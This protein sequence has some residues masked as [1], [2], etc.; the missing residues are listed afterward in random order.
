MSPDSTDEPESRAVSERDDA[1]NGEPRRRSEQIS[2]LLELIG[3]IG[4]GSDLEGCLSAVARETARAARVD[5]CAILLWRDERLVP[6]AFDVAEGDPAIEAANAFKALGIYNLD[7]IVVCKQAVGTRAPVIADDPV[8]AGLVP[9]SWA[10]VLGHRP[11]AVLP[12]MVGDRLLGTMHLSSNGAAIARAQLGPAEAVAGP[13]AL[14]IDHARLMAQTRRRL[15]EKNRLLRVALTIGSTLDP[16]EVLRRIARESA[17][18]VRADTGAI[19]FLGDD[20]HVLQPLVGYHVPKRFLEVVQRGQINLDDFRDIVTLLSQERRSI[21]SDDVARDPHF[22]H[23]LFRR[24]PMRSLFITPLKAGTKVLG[25]LVCVWWNRRHRF[26]AETLALL[27]G[28][29]GLAAVAL[30]NANRYSKAEAMAVTRERLRVARELHDTLNETIFSTALKLDACCRE[31]PAAMPDLRDKLEEVKRNTGNILG[32]IRQ[33]IYKVAPRPM[34]AMKLSE[35]VRAVIDAAAE[36]SDIR[37]EFL[38][39]GDAERLEIL[40]KIIQEALANVVKHSRASRAEVRIDVLADDVHFAVTDDGMGAG[41]DVSVAHLSQ[42]AGH[43]GLQQILERLE[44]LGG[45]LAFG[46]VAPAGFRIAGRFPVA[47]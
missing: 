9:A 24:L 3:V 43:F 32:Q 19:Y 10:P 25:I 36:L 30:S 34:G 44:A 22:D 41:P 35:R 6:A 12:L 38:E 21:W 42:V 39:Q 40:L 4:Q 8:G 37:V 47:R 2:G 28:I 27:E 5:Q 23:E 18:S 26:E 20:T 45:E 15:H 33:L 31:V 14:A 1:P 29:A 16:Q 13:L 17:R 11:T 7:D 46:N